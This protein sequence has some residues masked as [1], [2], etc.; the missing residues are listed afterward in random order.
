MDD[1]QALRRELARLIEDQQ[2]AMD[3]LRRRM[4]ELTWF[5][6]LADVTDIDLVRFTGPRAPGRDDGAACA[7]M[8]EGEY[9]IIRPA[10]SR[11]RRRN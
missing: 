10:P 9:G 11:S 2:Y 1:L 8:R 4:D 5:Q 7:S 6:R 3:V